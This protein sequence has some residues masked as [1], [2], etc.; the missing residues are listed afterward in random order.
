MKKRKPKSFDATHILEQF[1]EFN[2][3]QQNVNQI[4]LVDMKNTDVDGFYKCIASINC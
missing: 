1:M 2:F 4:L 3:G